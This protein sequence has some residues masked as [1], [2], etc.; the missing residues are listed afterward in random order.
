MRRLIPLLLFPVILYSQQSDILLLQKNQ[1]TIRQ[2]FAGSQID[3][4][5]TEH[6]GVSAVVDYIKRD[7]LFLLQYD[8]RMM[9]TMFGTFAPDTLA[10]YKVQYSVKNVYSFPANPRKFSF[11]TNGTLFML[12]GGAYLV[13]NM[14][15]T[16]REG[17]P[18]FAKDNR[19]N[20]IGGVAAFAAGLLLNKTQ[21]T[22][23]RLGKKYRLKYLPVANASNKQ[24]CCDPD[25][26]NT[27]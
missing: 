18:P 22:E 24:E 4:Y 26:T 13:L 5:T 8:I 2:F 14:V 20:I 6:M 11:I 27:K 3:F 16:L 10:V 23:Y 7:S 19:P 12:G 15:N 21:R 25:S 17:D 1:R 9:P